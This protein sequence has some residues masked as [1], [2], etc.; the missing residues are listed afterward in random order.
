[1]WYLHSTIQRSANGVWCLPIYIY[2]SLSDV[3]VVV[4]VPL[5]RPQL[6]TFGAAAAATD[7]FSV[8]KFYPAICLRRV[9]QSI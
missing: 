3:V 5:F 2:V 7:G 4:V 1:M 8:S 6:N 9:Q